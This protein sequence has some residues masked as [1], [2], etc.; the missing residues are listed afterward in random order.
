MHGRN[1]ENNAGS[2]ERKKCEGESV[3][4]VDKSRRAHIFLSWLLRLKVIVEL[5]LSFKL[6]VSSLNLTQNTML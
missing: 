1:E 3:V 2:G 4:H 6:N 5:A